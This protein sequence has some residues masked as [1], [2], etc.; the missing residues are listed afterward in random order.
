M[1]DQG[2][3]GSTVCAPVPP[4]LTGAVLQYR[5]Q[6]DPGRAAVFAA[7]NLSLTHKL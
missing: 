7:S 2:E 6:K 4:P 1:P 3:L 5:S